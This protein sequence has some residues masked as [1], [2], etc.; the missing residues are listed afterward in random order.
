MSS[1]KITTSNNGYSDLSMQHSCDTASVFECDAYS[2]PYGRTNGQTSFDGDA[3]RFK[4]AVWSKYDQHDAGAV[5]YVY[6]ELTEH[7]ANSG[8]F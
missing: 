2:N 3:R 1:F 7:S 6:H 5:A 4:V 8:M